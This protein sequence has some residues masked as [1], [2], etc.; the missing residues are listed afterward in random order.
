MTTKNQYTIDFQGLSLGNHSFSFEITDA[1]FKLWD[2][3]EILHGT[4]RADVELKK[5]ASMLELD[6]ALAGEVE[7]MCD[8]C[9]EPFMLPFTWD[10]HLVVKFSDMADEMEDDGD[11][12]WLQRAEG[13]LDLA[14]YIYE[15][16]ILSLPYQWVHPNLADCNADMISRFQIVSQDELERLEQE[17]MQT[18]EKQ[19]ETKIITNK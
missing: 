18:L 1:I 9:L 2:E 8:R 13:S 19:I 11:I 5:S 14:Q 15:S 12:M 10:G 6:I 7:V 4:G 3:S 17:T 16:I